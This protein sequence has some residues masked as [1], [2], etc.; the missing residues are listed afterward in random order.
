MA[1]A[2][3]YSAPFHAYTA[4]NAQLGPH[5]TVCTCGEWYR[6]PSSFFLANTDQPLRFLPC[7]FTG[8]LPQPFVHA[9]SRPSGVQH[10][11]PFRS[12]NTM[13]AERFAELQDC[14]WVVELRAG[15]GDCNVTL[16]DDSEEAIAFRHPFLN[17][18][19]T[20][21]LHRVLYV[22]GWHEAAIR[23]GSV[24]YHDY[25]VYKLKP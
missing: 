14:D 21:T 6:F 10:L 15:S 1:L 3:Y 17:A 13:N 19:A 2:K 4:L 11:Q 9:G 12:D 24:Q 22:P 18:A 20:A 8:Q 5:D 25:V 7:S 23:K 16:P